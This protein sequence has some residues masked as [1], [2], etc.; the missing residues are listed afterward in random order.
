MIRYLYI[1]DICIAAQ[2]PRLHGVGSRISGYNQSSTPPQLFFI[3][4]QATAQ[5]WIDNG[6][7]GLVVSSIDN[8]DGRSRFATTA[9][10][11]ITFEV[12]PGFPLG[13][14]NCDGFVNLL[15]VGPFVAAIT[16]GVFD[17]KADFD[18][19]GTVD[20]LDIAPFVLILTGG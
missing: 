14:V 13:D 10:A 4:D 3:V 11:A 18:E 19:N 2:R 8:G 16:S 12:G 17:P 7:P 20:L 1:V 5:S 6:L 9:T 15:D